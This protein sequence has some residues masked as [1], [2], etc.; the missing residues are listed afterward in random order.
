MFKST[1]LAKMFAGRRKFFRGPHAARGPHVR[2]LC[3]KQISYQR[4]VFAIIGFISY[5]AAKKNITLM[6]FIP[7]SDNIDLWKNFRLF[8]SVY[9]IRGWE[10]L[11]S[12]R[13]CANLD[14]VYSNF[15]FFLLTS[16]TKMAAMFN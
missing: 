3:L 8:Y 9:I 15:L 4:S 6:T 1:G 2:H 10:I 12:A 5:C 11:F 13:R 14:L 16:A 7:P